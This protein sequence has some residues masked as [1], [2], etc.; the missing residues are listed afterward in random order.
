LRLECDFDVEEV[1][2][3]GNT[4][5]KYT[6]R[7][8]TFKAKGA[9][10]DMEYDSDANRPKV[11]PQVLSLHLARG[12][13]FFIRVTPQG[14]IDKINGLSAVMG[15]AK[16]KIP[17]IAERDLL[18][19]LVEQYF[20]EAAIKREL[21]SRLAVFPDSA[22]PAAV[23]RQQDAGAG[24]IDI[25]DSWSR[26]ELVDDDKTLLKWTWRL[27]ERRGIAPDTIAVIDVNLVASPAPRSPSGE[28]GS[29]VEGQ[30]RFI[31]DKQEVAIGGVKTRREVK[32]Q[33]FGQIEIDEATGRI[34]NS[35]LTHD[36]VEI[37]LLLPEGPIRRP[38]PAPAPTRMHI[39]TTFQMIKRDSNKLP[40]AS[41][42]NQP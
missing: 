18:I 34:I 14:H 16:S 13:S 32:G 21:E 19:R 27:R 35:T 3:D 29:K 17:N 26:R 37:I 9:G 30:P 2:N 31:G 33:G 7:R 25:G 1:D 28:A 11:P 22:P 8:V 6:Y 15:N 36:L 42:A 5:A 39:V 40:V 38:P 4:W 12:E 10:L 24:A 23:L 20:A 41:E